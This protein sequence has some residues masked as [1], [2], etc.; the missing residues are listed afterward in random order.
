MATTI[1]LPA[2][3]IGK[4]FAKTQTLSAVRLLADSRQTTANRDSVAHSLSISNGSFHD[5]SDPNA[6]LKEYSDADVKMVKIP[7]GTMYK[8]IRIPDFQAEDA[9]N[10]VDEVTAMLPGVLAETLDLAAFGPEYLPSSPFSGFGASEAFEVDATPESWEAVLDDL[11]A[12]GYTK[13]LGMILNSSARGMIRKAVTAGAN[14]NTLNVNPAD[15]YL[16]GDAEAYFR[17]IGKATASGDLVG[18]V[19]DFSQAVSAFVEEVTIRVFTPEDSLTATTQNMV[20]VY[21]G[22]RV[23]FYAHPEA[24]RRLVLA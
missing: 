24:F 19:G 13:N 14:V 8:M 12:S 15:G 5:P 1:E 4:I 6:G 22:W 11:N 21:A 7:M 20:T 18:V 3:E 9:E 16:V 2:E 10:L 17:P 23:G